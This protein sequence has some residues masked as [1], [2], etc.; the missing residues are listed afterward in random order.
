MDTDPPTL[1]YSQ[2][3]KQH[4]KSLEKVAEEYNVKIEV[5]GFRMRNV[6]G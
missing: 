6:E 5:Y 1:D 3:Q 2:S 4:I